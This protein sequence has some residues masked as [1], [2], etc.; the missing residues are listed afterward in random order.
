LVRKPI[1][2]V[3]KKNFKTIASFAKQKKIVK[4]TGDKEREANEKNCSGIRYAFKRTHTSQKNGNSI[5][6]RN[7]KKND[8]CYPEK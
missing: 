6:L 8:G 3:Q 1:K 2:R 4:T 5:P 7:E